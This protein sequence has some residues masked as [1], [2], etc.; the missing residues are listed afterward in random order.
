MKALRK[1]FFIRNEGV[2]EMH[3]IDYT[4]NKYYLLHRKSIDVKKIVN[5]IFIAKT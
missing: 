1:I 5:M 3:S 2:T 4:R